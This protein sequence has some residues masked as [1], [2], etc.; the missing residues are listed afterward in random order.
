MGW[1]PN[2]RKILCIFGVHGYMSSGSKSNPW[3]QLILG[4]L[5]TYEELPKKKWSSLLFFF[6]RVAKSH[7]LVGWSWK[8]DSSDIIYYIKLVFKG[9]WKFSF[10]WCPTTTKCEVDSSK[11]RAE[12][13]IWSSSNPTTVYAGL[14]AIPRCLI[15]LSGPRSITKGKNKDRKRFQSTG[16]I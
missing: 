15:I 4:N 5:L 6:N 13:K 7:I 14:E 9:F 10:F 16:V 3:N 12:R 1:T 11:M 8:L 2:L